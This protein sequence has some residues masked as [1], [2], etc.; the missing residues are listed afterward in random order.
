MTQT[1]TCSPGFDFSLFNSTQF[2]LIFTKI[3]N[4][5]FWCQR[6]TLPEV[7]YNS[8]T[9]DTPSLDLFHTGEK[10][11]FT[12]FSCSVLLDKNLI[13]YKEIFN[14]MSTD[15]SSN[16][17]NTSFSDA[18]L[19]LG[20]VEVKFRDLFPIEISKLDFSII[21]TDIQPMTFNISFRY[22]WYYFA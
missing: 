17:V 7:T 9:Q 12:P 1:I 18:S 2:K 19:F 14:W 5:E 8:V 3:P 21:A 22:D 4:V 15:S 10:M 11:H 13:T 20:D 16:Q 6:V